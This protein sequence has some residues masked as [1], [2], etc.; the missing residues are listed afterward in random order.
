MRA[1]TFV[2]TSVCLALDLVSQ[3]FCICTISFWHVWYCTSHKFVTWSI[4]LSA[5]SPWHFW[6]VSGV[7]LL[8]FFVEFTHVGWVFISHGSLGM[9]L[10]I[11]W[12]EHLD[13]SFCKFV[14]LRVVQAEVIGVDPKEVNVPVVGGHAGITILP[15]LS[16]VRSSHWHVYSVYSCLA[17]YSHMVLGALL[18]DLLCMCAELYTCETRP[19]LRSRS[20]VRRLSTWQIVF[21]MG[22]QR[23]LR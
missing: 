13:T 9:S 16:Q 11:S 5:S 7:L 4:H 6:L 19:V 22:A 1:N 17:I 20:T 8:P 3:R 23:W 21:K 2:V 15:L 14:N 18:I 12:S 10:H